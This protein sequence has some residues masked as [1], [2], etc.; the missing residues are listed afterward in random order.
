M[1]K[2][3]LNDEDIFLVGLINYC[4]LIEYNSFGENDL[5]LYIKNLKCMILESSVSEIIKATAQEIRNAININS[6]KGKVQLG[7]LGPI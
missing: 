1:C 4:K 7:N 6:H 3:K 2:R 5:K